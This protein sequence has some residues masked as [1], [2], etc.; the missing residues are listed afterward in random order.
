MNVSVLIPAYNE[1]ENLGETLMSIRLFCPGAEIIVGD[2][3]SSDGTAAVARRYGARV[4][5]VRGGTVGHVRNCLA[6]EATGDVLIFNDADVRLTE[7]WRDR[8][9]E[10][11]L[12]QMI[13][14]AIRPPQGAGWIVDSWFRHTG[15]KTYVGTGHMIVPRAV[16]EELGGFDTRLSSGEDVDLSNRAKA[17]VEVI[18]DPELVVVH[19]DFPETLKAFFKREVW[20]GTGDFVDLD[21]VLHSKV[22]IMALAFVGLILLSA[23]YWPLLLVAATIPAGL[24]MLKFPRLPLKQRGGNA[25]LWTTYLFA[26]ACSAPFAHTEKRLYA[27]KG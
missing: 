10:L 7:A 18:P 20:H 9:A 1:A 2:H 21:H 27:S 22:A 14:G 4:I 15:Q 25:I 16:F 23:V 11:D 5:T 6:L 12:G 26:R 17:L 13:G 8:F 19:Q 3:E 24:S